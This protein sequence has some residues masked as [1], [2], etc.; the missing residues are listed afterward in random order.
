MGALIISAMR[1]DDVAPLRPYRSHVALLATLFFLVFGCASSVRPDFYQPSQSDKPFPMS[2]KVDVRAPDSFKV[3]SGFT[4]KFGSALSDAVAKAITVDFAQITGSY[5]DLQA[6]ASFAATYE[7]PEVSADVLGHVVLNVAFL[8]SATG[9]QIASISRSEAV[10]WHVNL[11]EMGVA[12]EGAFAFTSV[13]GAPLTGALIAADYRDLFEAST[14]ELLREVTMAIR[15]DPA[16]N[17]FAANYVPSTEV[18]TVASTA[19]EQSPSTSAEKTGSPAPSAL[20]EQQSATNERPPAVRPESNSYLAKSTNHQ[21]ALSRRVAL[22]IGNSDYKYVNRLSNPTNDARLVA[23]T[24]QDEGFKLTDSKALIDLDKPAFE[25]ALEKFGDEVQ[26]SKRHGATTALFYYAGHGMQINGVNYLVP[27]SANPNKAADAPLQMV[28]ADAAL[29]Q[30]QDGGARLKIMILDAC[31]NN[32][33]RSITRGGNSGLHSMDAPDG[34]LI[35]YA[36]KPDGVAGDGDGPDS[37]YT[38]ALVEAF[39]RPGLGLFEVFNEAALIVKRKTNDTQQPWTAES[40][41]EGK[42]CFAGCAE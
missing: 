27:I 1:A 32:P 41:I 25:Q 36:T 16:L 8:N 37:P 6:H 12:L 3:A 2:V 26:E 4:V 20:P 10:T 28:S 17:R 23:A 14:R 34:T 21:A 19:G 31:R 39:R 7:V 13:V 11:H 33:F 5:S 42:F 29:N 15:E 24:L 22:V 30:M 38:E 35:A 40:A 9:L 18:V